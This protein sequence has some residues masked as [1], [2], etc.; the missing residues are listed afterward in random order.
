MQQY[1]DS[2]DMTYDKNL[3]PTGCTCAKYKPSNK[4]YSTQ[5]AVSSSTRLL[6][7]NVEAVTNTAYDANKKLCS[8]CSI[9]NQFTLKN[10]VANCKITSPCS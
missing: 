5:G 1:R 8:V 10:K 4:K 9:T 7:L 3:N 2:N 6:R